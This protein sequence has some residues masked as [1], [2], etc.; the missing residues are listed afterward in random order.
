MEK[1]EFDDA[2]N[3]LQIALTELHRT[4][5][6]ESIWAILF[7]NDLSICYS[8]T[9]NSSLSKGY[10]DKALALIEENTSS[11]EFISHEPKIG[12]TNFENIIVSSLL[13]ELRLIALYNRAMAENNSELRSDAEKSFRIIISNYCDSL[14]FNYQSAVLNLGRMFIDQGRGKEA[15]ELLEELLVN[16]KDKAGND[17]NLLEDDFRYWDALLQYVSSLIDQADYTSARIRL[18]EKFFERKITWN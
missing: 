8:G 13:N 5:F 2:A 10:A 18:N 17:K 12:D 1:E 14:R 6:K 11:Q 4:E 9:K 16:N 7:Y 15:A 3:Q